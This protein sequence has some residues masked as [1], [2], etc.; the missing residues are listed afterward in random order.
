MSRNNQG[1]RSHRAARQLSTRPWSSVLHPMDNIW[2]VVLCT[3]GWWMQSKIS[4]KIR[5]VDAKQDFWKNQSGNCM[6]KRQKVTRLWCYILWQPTPEL[7]LEKFHGLRSLV[8]YS[9]Q[10]HKE[11]D[12]TDWI[13]QLASYTF[14]KTHQIY[15]WNCQILLY[16]LIHYTSRM[17]IFGKQRTIAKSGMRQALKVQAIKLQRFSD[18]GEFSSV[19]KPADHMHLF[20]SSVTSHL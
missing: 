15:T 8:G 17:L 14:V 16:L 20:P 3:D 10:G 18:W 6:Q 4:G 13:H 12:T 1:R 19:L 5:V 2:P 11:S 7:L 9:P